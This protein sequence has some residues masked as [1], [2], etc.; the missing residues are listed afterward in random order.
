MS[1]LSTPEQIIDD[2]PNGCMFILVN[3]EHRENEGNFIIP[4]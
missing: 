2:A 3:D 1:P 4:S